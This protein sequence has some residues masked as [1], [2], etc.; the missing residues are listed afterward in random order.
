[1]LMDFLTPLV[2]PI[3]QI[4]W[5]NLL[6]SGDNAVVIALACRNLDPSQRRIGM[7]LGA[8]AAILLRIAFTLVTSSLLDLPF[9]KFGGSL[10]LFWIAVKLLRDEHVDP[11][12]IAGESGLWK[13]VQTIAIADIV[14]SLTM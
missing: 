5:I 12:K 13:A 2:L 1:M 4:I 8:G 3:L 7:L 9:V 6:L 10:L 11:D 14:M